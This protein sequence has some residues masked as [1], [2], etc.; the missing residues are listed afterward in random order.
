MDKDLK[1]LK[2]INWNEIVN[3]SKSSLP[4]LLK[5]LIAVLIPGLKDDQRQSR[6]SS[7][8][9]RMVMAYAILAL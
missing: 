8:I 6:A 1:D 3:E 9:P 4:F 5:V 2:E 7:N